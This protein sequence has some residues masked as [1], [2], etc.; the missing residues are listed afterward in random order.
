MPYSIEQV[1]QTKGLKVVHIN[2]RSLIQHFDEFSI[3]FLDGNF[4]IVIVTE[5]WLHANC[6]DSLVCASGY[7][8]FRLDRQVTTES[9]S[10]KRGGGIALYIRNKFTVSNWT[11]LDVSDRDVEVISLSCKLGHNKRLNLT[12]VYRPPNGNV[13]AALDKIETIVNTIRPQG[14]PL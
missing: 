7:N 1:S 12:A 11:N 2:T 3:S 14:V 9:G 6:A 5:S 8:L 10:V 4:D 13:Q